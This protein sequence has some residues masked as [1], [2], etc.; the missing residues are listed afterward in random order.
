MFQIFKTFVSVYE[1]HNFTRTADKLYLSQPT[2]S[3]QI[4]K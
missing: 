2:V 3:S 4:K 1:T